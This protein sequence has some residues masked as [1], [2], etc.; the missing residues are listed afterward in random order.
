[1]AAAVK[2]NICVIQP[3]GYVF[4]LGLL[5]QAIYFQYYLQE[6]GYRVELTKNRLRA[7][8]VNFI[9]GGHLGFDPDLAARY[10]C[11]LVNLEQ[12][13]SDGCNL[14]PAYVEMLGRLPVIDY[15]PA[16]VAAYR[17]DPSEV[18]I[19]PFQFMPYLRREPLTPVAERP[20][21]VLFIGSVNQ[22][23]FDLFEKIRAA[24]VEVSY[25]DGPLFGPE[26]DAFIR[27]AK[28][29][30]NTGFYGRNR[31]EQT[32]L[33]HSLSLGTP[34]VSTRP[35]VGND[36]GVFEDCTTW[37]DEA[38][39]VDFFRNTF[40]TQEWCELAQAQVENF[41]RTDPTADFEAML[42]HFALL[43]D[44]MPQAHRPAVINTTSDYRLGWLNL[45]EDARLAPDAV[46][47]LTQA[48][49]WPQQV[50]T[51]SF[52]TIA[53]QPESFSAILANPA[54]LSGAALDNLMRNCMALLQN[55]GHVILSV[56][57]KGA[58]VTSIFHKSAA[59]DLT[60]LME[61]YTESFWQMG[62]FSHRFAVEGTAVDGDVQIVL[63]KV[64]TTPRERNSMRASDPHFGLDQAPYLA[65]V[66]G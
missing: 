64:E 65:A 60:A 33:S 5:D 41:T 25:F 13:G 34:V 20:I 6:M 35:N 56:P 1:M 54:R 49:E 53:L 26:R 23:R 51:A 38:E 17:A 10:T 48:L 62:W 30:L 44:A 12:V 9:F 43:F 42:A 28:C 40:P 3:K 7:D 59:P 36:C 57:A 46:L 14:A 11:V 24:G 63:R 15:D 2:L 27:Q 37:V 45:A 29:M 66:A 55:Q 47:D 4:S 22:R 50:D 61:P 8:A 18:A 19:V 39:I 16:N 32:R 52:G 31:L 58:D 21:D